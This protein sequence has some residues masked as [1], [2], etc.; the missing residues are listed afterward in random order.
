LWGA[1]RPDVTLPQAIDNYIGR[2]TMYPFGIDDAAIQALRDAGYDDDGI[3]EMTLA[4]GI[5]TACAVVEPLFGVL[6]G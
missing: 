1:T 2:V 5:G 3:Y 6:Y 4:A